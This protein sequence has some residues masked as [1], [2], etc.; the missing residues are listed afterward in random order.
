MSEIILSTSEPELLK[1]PIK[2]PR[3]F[4]YQKFPYPRLVFKNL[5]KSLGGLAPELIKMANLSLRLA[6]ARIENHFNNQPKL[7]SRYKNIVLRLFLNI[8][9]LG[10]EEMKKS[11]N[12]IAKQ[13]GQMCDKT[14]GII[15]LYGEEFERSS[16]GFVTTKVLSLLS[17]EQRDK[18][19]LIDGK[20]YTQSRG[21]EESL[22]HIAKP[23][24]I[25]HIIFVDDWSLGGGHIS[26]YLDFCK[27]I[28]HL[29]FKFETHIKMIASVAS[30]KEWYCEHGSFSIDTF[31]NTYTID[32]Y[33]ELDISD[34]EIHTLDDNVILKLCDDGRYLT[35][36]VFSDS[37]LQ[38]SFLFTPDNVFPLL[39]NLGIDTNFDDWTMIKFGDNTAD[40]PCPINLE[41][42]L[43]YIP[44]PTETHPTF[45]DLWTKLDEYHSDKINR[46]N[47]LKYLQEQSGMVKNNGEVG[48]YIK[49]E[50]LDTI[51]HLIKSLRYQLR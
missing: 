40:N 26:E 29:G 49:K 25:E 43:K 14:K 36:Q 4:R 45:I 35:F 20:P 41:D 44:R 9:F 22:V 32:G 50:L 11:L 7:I 48:E 15:C 27:E 28:N 30:T 42:Y 24:E 16:S 3:L 1:L 23:K 34:E 21:A 17:Q 51:D 39:T 13:I 47:L 12:I 8:R 19:F 33:R 31:Y 46:E 37:L 18:I 6:F 2:A 38:N 10:N 5:D